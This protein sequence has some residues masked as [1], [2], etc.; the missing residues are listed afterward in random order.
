M[1]AGSAV[2]K[3]CF[4]D[5]FF[6]VEGFEVLLDDLHARVLVLEE[7]IRCAVLVLE[8]TSLPPNEIETLND[9]LRRETGAEHCFSLVTHTFSAPHF[10]PDHILK[11][12]EEKSKKGKNCK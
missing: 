7:S 2:R 5:G 6:P 1:N 10:L 9:I 4:P 3:L 11:T 12:E 8:M